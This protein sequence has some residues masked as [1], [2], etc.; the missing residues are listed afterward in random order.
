MSLKCVMLPRIQMYCSKCNIHFI[1]N[2]IIYS[3]SLHKLPVKLIP[4]KWWTIIYE[5]NLDMTI[6]WWRHQQ[7]DCCNVGWFI[8]FNATYNNISI[9]SR[10]SVL[11]VEGTGVPEENHRS[12][13]SYR[14]TL[15]HNVT[16]TIP[17]HERG[18]NSQL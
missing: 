1:S 3:R 6:L 4:L 10:W 5:H 17:R 11:L 13:A 16:S 15:S 2:I 18:S 8:V 9:I 7:V 14:Q 12:V